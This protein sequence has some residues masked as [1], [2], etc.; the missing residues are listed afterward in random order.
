MQPTTTSVALPVASLPVSQVIPVFFLLVFFVWLV[1]TLVAAYHW[2][3]YSNNTTL[4]LSALSVHLI[5][6]AWLAVFTVSG[7]TGIH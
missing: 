6:S 7:L 5:V 1:Y 4:A 2:L 3:R